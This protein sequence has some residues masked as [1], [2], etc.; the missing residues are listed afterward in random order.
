MIPYG[1]QDITDADIEAVRNVL[2]SEFITQGPEIP[3]FENALAEVCGAAHAVAVNSATAA[4]HLA[5]AALGLGP[6]DR[7]WTSANTFVASANAGHYCGASV[8]FVDI[9]PRTYNLCTEALESKL[10]VAQREGRL[11]K[12]VMPVHFAGQSCDM[13][14]IADLGRTY[15]FRIIEDA[16]HAIGGWYGKDR[17]G[18]CRHSD[19]TVFSFHPVK[20]ITTAEGGMALTNDPELADRMALLRS[21]GITRAAE[22]MRN[23]SE[24][25]W[26]YEQVGLGFN[27]RMTDIQAALG[28]SQ[29]DRLDSYVDARH[30]VRARYDAELADLPLILPHQAD[31]QRSAVHLYPVLIRD[32]APVDRAE[33]FARLRALGINVNVLYIPVYRQP[34]HQGFGYRPEDFPVS[35]DYYRRT[36]AIPMFATLSAADQGRVV[37]SLHEA[38]S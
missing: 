12:V 32:E 28:R 29:L 4:L 33:A 35:E 37:A 23:G 8:D 15:G 24:G 25:P 5:C 21:H 2:C 17:V 10:V 16:S 13:L 27:Y 30:T 3:A 34:F 7:L 9:D 20:I 26:Y 6:G 1:R 14:R 22:R 18:G 36:I 38:L 31:F 11:P 19:I